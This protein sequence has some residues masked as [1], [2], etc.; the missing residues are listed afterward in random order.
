[1]NNFQAI[2][3]V[4]A[5]IEAVKSVLG[6]AFVPGVKVELTKEQRASVVAMVTEGLTSG[7]VQFSPEARAKHEAAGTIKTYVGGLVTNWLAKSPEL[8]GGVKHEIKAPG[9]RSESNELKQA[10]ALKAYLES[11]GED[12]TAVDSFIAKLEADAAAKATKTKELDLSALPEEL[13]ALAKVG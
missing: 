2:K 6:D 10:R 9:S 12:V 4:D 3:Q 5:V 1:M 11:R 13:R 8:N 7:T